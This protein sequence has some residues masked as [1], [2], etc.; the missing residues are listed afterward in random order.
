MFPWQKKSLLQKSKMRTK[1][2]FEEI[3]FTKVKDDPFRSLTRT[4][5][6]IQR[7]TEQDLARI[8]CYIHPMGIMKCF[9]C[10]KYS[11]MQYKGRA[12]ANLIRR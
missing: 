4:R 3:S 2:E 12:Q 5:I 6:N 8:R 1:T 11:S 7:E 10:N 9:L